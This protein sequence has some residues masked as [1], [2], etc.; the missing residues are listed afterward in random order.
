M[1]KKLLDYDPVTR[2]ADWHCYDHS[3]KKTFI[4]TVQDVEGIIEHNKRK[5]NSNNTSRYQD[6]GDYY[7]F[8]T[9]PNT[10]LLDWKKK[11]NVDWT[12]KEDLPRIEKLL[13]SN[14]YRYL[15]TVDRI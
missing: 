8:A 14:E 5:Q 7:H 9:V 3:T 1:G 4:K 11:Y 6:K 2:T 13:K 12:K 10:V 15:R